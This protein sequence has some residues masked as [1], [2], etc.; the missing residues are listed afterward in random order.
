M[1]DA[2]AKY[3]G[4][5]ADITESYWFGASEPIEFTKTINKINE[6][7][8]RIENKLSEGTSASEL[9]TACNIKMPHAVGHGI[10]IEEHDLPGGIGDKSKWKLQSGMVLAIEPAIYTKKF[11]VRIEFD[12]LITKNGF[13]KL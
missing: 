9:W 13:E 2:G 12:Y 11:G 10:G 7:L 3:K 6:A 5:Y 8:A 1:I 4:Y